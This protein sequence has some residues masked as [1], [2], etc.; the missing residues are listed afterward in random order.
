MGLEEHPKAALTTKPFAVL[1][2]DNLQL[3]EAVDLWL[4][5]DLLLT[6]QLPVSEAILAI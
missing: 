2:G 5:R 6:E 1:M 3:L 4:V